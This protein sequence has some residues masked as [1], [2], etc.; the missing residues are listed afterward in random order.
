MKE[1]KI[2]SINYNIE[3]GFIPWCLK[4]EL[5]LC[6]S[7]VLVW[8]RQEKKKVRQFLWHGLI[9]KFVQKARALL[10]PYHAGERRLKLYDDTLYQRNL[11]NRNQ[12]VCGGFLWSRE[13]LFWLLG[14]QHGNYL[15]QRQVLDLLFIHPP[16]FMS[17]IPDW[18]QQQKSNLSL[19]LCLK[20][21]KLKIPSVKTTELTPSLVKIHAVHLFQQNHFMWLKVRFYVHL[22]F[23]FWPGYSFHWHWCISA[24]TW[25]KGTRPDLRSWPHCCC[26]ADIFRRTYLTEF[27]NQWEVMCSRL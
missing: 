25:Q 17:Q 27:A 3:F 1:N 9:G 24:V 8:L 19:V 5:T 16:P 13:E 11:H 12:D 10:S 21:L 14:V 20:C 23:E 4:V 6:I 15:F 18:K 26:F 22:G 2:V 7:V